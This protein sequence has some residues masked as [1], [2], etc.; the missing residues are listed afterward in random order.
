[1]ANWCSGFFSSTISCRWLCCNYRPYLQQHQQLA[2]LLR[3]LNWPW[4]IQMTRD[5][6]VV[7]PKD[8]LL[9]AG[10]TSQ[11]I[12]SVVLDVIPPNLPWQACAISIPI[13]G[14]KEKWAVQASHICPHFSRLPPFFASLGVGQTAASAPSYLRR[15]S[16]AAVSPSKQESRT[17]AIWE[18]LTENSFFTVKKSVHPALAEMPL[19]RS[20]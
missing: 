8:Y 5:A 17:A 3:W 20:R 15:A 19:R 11:P 12:T 13:V 6:F 2:L 9:R 18:E 14:L 16:R 10:F 7:S 4:F 1:M